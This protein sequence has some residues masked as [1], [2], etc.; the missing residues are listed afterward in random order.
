MITY[1]FLFAY[2]ISCFYND[3]V[4]VKT[5][6]I[7]ETVILFRTYVFSKTSYQYSSLIVLNPIRTLITQVLSC[8]ILQLTVVGEDTYAL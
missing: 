1:I 2:R 7:S 5:R 6:F 4:I 8:H 3:F